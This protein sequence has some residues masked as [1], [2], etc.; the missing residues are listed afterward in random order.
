MVAGPMD[1]TP[2]AMRNATQK[3]YRSI[4]SEPMSQGTR[5]HQ[6]AEYIVFESPLAMLCD[7]PTNYLKEPECT[8]FIV[9]IPAVW[10]KTIALDGK[11]AE[12]AV[13]AREKDGIWYIGGLNNWDS[14]ILTLDLSFLPEGKYEIELFAD[15]ANAHRVATDYKRTIHSLNKKTLE[16]SMAPGGGFAGR[17]TM[18]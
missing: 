2:G 11:V 16:V 13:I 14:R 12:Y 10:D 4:N 17:I 6:I 3:N 8:S 9:E 15:G 5:C 1:Y 18:Q 7:N